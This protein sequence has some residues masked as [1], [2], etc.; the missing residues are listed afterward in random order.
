MPVN[1]GHRVAAN[2]SR[3][4]HMRSTG[5]RSRTCTTRGSLQL[6]FGNCTDT[7][8]RSR[9]TVPLYSELAIPDTWQRQCEPGTVV[10][11]SLTGSGASSK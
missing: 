7:M 9:R 5:T 2:A 3:A 10:Y 6:L 4:T 11:S 8:Y 1:G